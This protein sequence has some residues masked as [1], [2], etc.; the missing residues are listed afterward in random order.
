MSRHGLS[1]RSP[2]L[3]RSSLTLRSAPCAWS[4]SLM[5]WDVV[6]PCAL[7][8]HLTS[9]PSRAITSSASARRAGK[10]SWEGD[11]DSLPPFLSLDFHSSDGLGG[12]TDS[13]PP[14]LGRVAAALRT[15]RASLS[16]R[17]EKP[18]SRFSTRDRRLEAMTRTP[19]GSWCRRIAV[20]T[21]LRCCP[22]G[23]ERRWR[24]VSTCASRSSRESRAGCT[25]GR[26]AHAQ[27]SSAA[28]ETAAATTPL[29]QSRRVGSEGRM[30]CASGSRRSGTRRVVM[31]AA[32]ET[33][34]GP[35]MRARLANAEPARHPPHGRSAERASITPWPTGMAH[36]ATAAATAARRAI[37]G[38]AGSGFRRLPP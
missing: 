13:S 2:A 29:E 19:V 28:S 6:R 18:R 14:H 26:G 36:S 33:R 30:F 8:A 22:P 15:S 25:A 34:G 20:S 9:Q 1:G 4:T 17:S 10:S 7:A 12:C 16:R 5:S 38:L 24:V 32:I 35:W 21:L 31:A 23:P 3:V 11:T 27:G 37:I